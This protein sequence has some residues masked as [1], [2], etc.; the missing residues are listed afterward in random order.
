MCLREYDP[1]RLFDRISTALAE[2]EVQY[3]EYW[4]ERKEWEREVLQMREERLRVGRLGEVLVKDLEGV[5][6]R[7]GYRSVLERPGAMVGMLSQL[8]PS[9]GFPQDSVQT[10]SD[11]PQFKQLVRFCESPLALRRS[12]LAASPPPR[13]SVSTPGQRDSPSAGKSLFF[14][15]V[16]CV[17]DARAIHSLQLSLERSG[18]YR[19]I[20]DRCSFYSIVLLSASSDHFRPLR[21]G[22]DRP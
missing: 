10:L 1:R 20:V 2:G 12:I 16:S 15:I 7:W 3:S 5:F 18:A 9:L 19:I 8:L 14:S 4:G 22:Q 21:K 13:N 6:D 11:A 17:A